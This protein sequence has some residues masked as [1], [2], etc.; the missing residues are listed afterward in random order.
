V[1][2]ASEMARNIGY[3]FAVTGDVPPVPI[4]VAVSSVNEPAVKVFENIGFQV[5]QFAEV[6]VDPNGKRI[7]FRYNSDGRAA[8]GAPNLNGNGAPK[9][10]RSGR[11]SLGK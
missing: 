9:G 10:V 6:F 3:T 1:D 2:L 7:E 5:A 4:M 8:A 11:T